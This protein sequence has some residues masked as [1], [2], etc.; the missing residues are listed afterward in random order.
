MTK[1]VGPTG[2]E[3][4]AQVHLAS[5]KVHKVAGPMRP[6]WE[7]TNSIIQGCSMSSLATAALSTVWARALEAEDS[8]TDTRFKPLK[9]TCAPN[10]ED[11]GRGEEEGSISLGDGDGD[12]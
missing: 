2:L 1:W 3:T 10:Q 12:Y 8:P 9:S 4:N 5:K 11:G 6:T 7:C